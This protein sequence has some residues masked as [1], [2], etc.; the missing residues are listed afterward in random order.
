MINIFHNLSR[1]TIICS[2]LLLCLAIL[3]AF[4]ISESVPFFIV[5]VF[6]VAIIFSTMLV[7]EIKKLLIKQPFTFFSRKN[8]FL[9]LII[10][11]VSLL[12]LFLEIYFSADGS[13]VYHTGFLY[14]TRTILINLGQVATLAAPIPLSYLA[15]QTLLG[16]PNDKGKT[17][18]T[19]RF[20]LSLIYPLITFLIFAALI[21]FSGWGAYVANEYIADIYWG[22]YFCGPSKI[23]DAA[24][25]VV[26]IETERGMSTGFW[27]DKDLI[28]TNNHVVLFNNNIDVQASGV[29]YFSADVV[30]TD[31]IKDLAILKIEKIID[32]EN[33][34]ILKWRK[35]WPVLAEDVYA[36]GFPE[37]AYDVTAT[38]GIVS[39]LISDDFDGTKLIQTD[40]AVNPGN[41]GG[42]MVDICG[43]VLG[44]TTSTL[45]D[46]ENISFAVDGS[47][48][49]EQ[50]DKMI[51]ASRLVTPIEIGSGQTGSEVETVIKY[52]LTLSRG[53]FEKAYDFYSQ[54]LKSRVLFDG[55]KESYKNTFAIR[56]MGAN[57]ISFGSVEVS[58]RTL[59]LPDKE[60]EDYIPR[61]FHGE[62]SLV[63][64][65]GIWKLNYSN[66]RQVPFETENQ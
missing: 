49:R 52:Y 59:D 58:F 19:V 45:Q 62:W 14:V 37:G 51:A 60:N 24:E 36:L 43:R 9:F 3:S 8:F 42:P 25:G 15:F 22:K 1:P 40:A 47:R 31:A 48:I 29:T 35:K 27:I 10:F 4:E 6:A 56:F 32:Y 26:R 2:L 30:Q 7:L 28:L 53:D 46:A 20:V 65:H 63:K 18:T 41:S 13:I 44:I 33:P 17:L 34:K 23:E 50:L 5:I 11:L 61:E 16:R 54:G 66:I 12:L 64:E 38:R 21:I 55:W 57:K 39:S